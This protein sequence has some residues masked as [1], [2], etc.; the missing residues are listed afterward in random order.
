MKNIILILSILFTGCS[1]SSMS[2][3]SPSKLIKEISVI[4]IAPGSGVLGDAIGLEL[5]NLGYRV[6][7][8]NQ[9]QSIIGR[10]GLSEFE[11]TTTKGYSVL[12]NKGI[13]AVLVSKAIMGYDSKPESASVRVT[14]TENGS[15]LVGVTWQNG[16][17]GIKGSLDDRTMRDNLSEA[18]Q[19][20]AKELSK[21]MKVTKK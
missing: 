6:I 10:V 17:G 21:R 11:I 15:I 14:D 5:F 20:I 16:W 8:A 12:K 4:A 18:A 7:D 2:V 9:A 19:N 13:E 3:N 1:S